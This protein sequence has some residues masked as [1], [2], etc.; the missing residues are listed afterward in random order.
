MDHHILEEHGCV[1]MKEHG[2][3]NTEAKD[4]DPVEDDDH[5]L[6]NTCK[7]DGMNALIH[8]TFGTSVVATNDDDVDDDVEDDIE[9]INDIPLLEKV[10]IPLYEGSQSTLLSIVL[11]L[12]NLKVM[13]GLSN[14]TMSCMLRFFI[15]AIIV[16]KR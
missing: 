8:D 6:E 11:V 16:Y 7:D 5:E 14:I 2:G 13:N 15:Y 3:V 1:N 9:A 10:T 12:V 4:H